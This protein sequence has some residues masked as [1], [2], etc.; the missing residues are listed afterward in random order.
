MM[1]SCFSSICVLLFLKNQNTQESRIYIESGF[2]LAKA[3]F[4]VDLNDLNNKNFGD[5]KKC[6]ILQ[7][8]K[9]CIY[10]FH[11]LFQCFLNV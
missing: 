7:N 5:T 3:Y 10:K 9:D 11:K 1:P 6:Q 4:H 8:S 2:T